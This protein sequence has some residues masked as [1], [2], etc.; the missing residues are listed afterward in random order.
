MFILTQSEI[1]QQQDLLKKSCEDEIS[2]LLH[3]GK[4]YFS[5]LFPHANIKVDNQNTPIRL[6]S[7]TVLDYKANKILQWTG[8]ILDTAIKISENQD[9][10]EGTPDQIMLPE[11]ISYRIIE[12]LVRIL[13]CGRDLTDVDYFFI[14][15][16]SQAINVDSYEV[17]YIIEQIQYEARKETFNIIKYHMTEKQREICAMLLLK[18]IRADDKVHPAEIKYFEIVSQLLDNDQA[19]LEKI[20]EQYV[21][22]EDN[23]PVYL[24]DHVSEFMFKYLVEIV[25][26][27]GHYDPEESHFIKEIGQAFDFD[28]ARQDEF[29]QPIAAALMVKTDLFQSSS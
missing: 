28:V 14:S 20:E 21:D 26:C 9:A 24:T 15:D 11:F 22:L 19:K 1:F 25:M 13:N 27:D 16:V 2:Q 23:L 4:D 17:Y 12:A 7:E 18:A 10:F 6:S 8:D 5:A 29:I 3:I